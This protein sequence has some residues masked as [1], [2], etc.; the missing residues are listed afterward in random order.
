MVFTARAEPRSVER[1]LNVMRSGRI[2]HPA[3]RSVSA[4]QYDGKSGRHL[5]KNLSCLN[6]VKTDGHQDENGHRKVISSG[7]TFN[8][9]PTSQVLQSYPHA[10]LQP[11]C[12]EVERG[13]RQ[14]WRG[15]SLGHEIGCAS[16]TITQSID[17]S[18]NE[19]WS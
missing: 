1:N 9:W 15:D 8:S 10:T 17:A 19:A 4:G 7:G 14:T 16:H 11:T 2:P 13:E 5:I 3:A 12:K 18:S 6:G